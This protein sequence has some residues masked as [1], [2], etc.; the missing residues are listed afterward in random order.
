MF[1]VSGMF[2]VRKIIS[3]IQIARKKCK[4]TPGFGSYMKNEAGL[5]NDVCER[6]VTGKKDEFMKSPI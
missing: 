5:R 2:A 3:G 1:F 4:V 6:R